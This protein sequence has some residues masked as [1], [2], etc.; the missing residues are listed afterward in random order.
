MHGHTSTVEYY[1]HVP[2]SAG[3]GTGVQA[4][5]E[6]V[7][8]AFRFWVAADAAAWWL[9]L[10]SEAWTDGLQQARHQE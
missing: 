2:A 10:I 5:G 7:V 6:V 8:Q 9:I 4:T 1:Y 3:V